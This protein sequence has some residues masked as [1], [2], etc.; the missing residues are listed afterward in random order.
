MLNGA[1]CKKSA[2]MLA[3]K[4]SGIGEENRTRENS[5]NLQKKKKIFVGIFLKKCLRKTFSCG[6]VV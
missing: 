2:G 5:K 3:Q 4:N 6:K 1:Y